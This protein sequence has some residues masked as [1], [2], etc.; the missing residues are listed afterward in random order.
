MWREPCVTV[1]PK[2]PIADPK[3]ETVPVTLAHATVGFDVAANGGTVAKADE[4][5]ATGKKAPNLKML[6]A[7]DWAPIRA[8]RPEDGSAESATAAPIQTIE[9]LRRLI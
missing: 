3:G 4:T 2:V 1:S 5:V 7:P 6:D 8:H 9:P